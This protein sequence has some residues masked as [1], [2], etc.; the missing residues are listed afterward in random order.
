MPPGIFWEEISKRSIKP[1][2]KNSPPKQKDKKLQKDSGAASVS[3]PIDSEEE[4]EHEVMMIET[5][6]MQPYLAYLVNKEIPADPV[7][8][9]R[10]IR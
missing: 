1:K 5:P 8:A 2:K 10:V 9:R 4:E 3:E 6:W 7:E